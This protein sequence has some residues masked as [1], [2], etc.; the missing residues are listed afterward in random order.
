MKSKSRKFIFNPFSGSQVQSGFTLVE[1]MVVVAIIGILAS[2]G[3][4]QF[5]KFQAKARQSEA[6]S[7]LAALYQVEKA[8]FAE[9]GGFTTCLLDVGLNY[10]GNERYY[11]VGFN[12]DHSASDCNVAAG[13]TVKC[14]RVVRSGT[15]VDCSDA[16]GW[17]FLATKASGG[18]IASNPEDITGATGVIAL[19]H[20]ISQTAF[21]ASAHGRIGSSAAL[22]SWSINESKTITNNRVGIP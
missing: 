18:T 13:A 4:P 12:K 5:Q 20:A 1:L 16:N 2:I 22:D 17:R 3:V 15:G 19:A 7:S 9:S 6:K 14:H 11:S 21:T 10:E 8:Q